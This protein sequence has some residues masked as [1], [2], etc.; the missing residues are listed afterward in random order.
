[1]PKLKA[2]IDKIDI[3]NYLLVLENSIKNFTLG[4]WVKDALMGIKYLSKWNRATI[5]T[6]VETIRNFTDFFSFLVPVEFK[7]FEHKDLQ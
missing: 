3:L 5:F 4:A 1:M 2:L 6:D 7:G